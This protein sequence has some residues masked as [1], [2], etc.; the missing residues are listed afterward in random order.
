MA[1]DIQENVNAH[2][3]EKYGRNDPIIDV[4]PNGDWHVHYPNG[5]P[6]SL[7]KTLDKNRMD[8]AP[9]FNLDEYTEDD[10]RQLRLPRTHI[11]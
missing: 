2:F 1:D 10:V 6:D 4:Q 11:K 8:D 5:I 9:D 3:D 7:Q